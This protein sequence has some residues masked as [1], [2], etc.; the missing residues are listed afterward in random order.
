VLFLAPQAPKA[1]GISFFEGRSSG[2]RRRSPDPHLMM[3]TFGQ[4][5]EFDRS[6]WEEVDRIAN[7]YNRLVLFDAHIARGARA[8]FGDRMENARLFQNFFFNVDGAPI[9][10]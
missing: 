9:R 2:L 10:E 5:A 8:Y 3:Q 7:I 6:R 1:A 4:G